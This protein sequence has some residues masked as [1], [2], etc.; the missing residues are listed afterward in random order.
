MPNEESMKILTKI[1]FSNDN[2]SKIDDEENLNTGKN[3]NNDEVDNNMINEVAKKVLNNCH[4]Y[5]QK[6]NINN[7]NLYIKGKK[8]NN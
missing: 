7:N 5:S 8:I 2:N 6:K 1:A 3:R 4:F